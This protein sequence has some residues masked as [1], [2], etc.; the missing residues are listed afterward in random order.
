MTWHDRFSLVLFNLILFRLA[1]S[2]GFCLLF[3]LVNPWWLL[4]IQ[5]IYKRL[6]QKLT[7]FFL[8]FFIVQST[9]AKSGIIYKMF[10]VQFLKKKKTW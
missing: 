4:F 10:L 9:E 3:L 7:V 1:V 2:A 6:S 5:L 8:S